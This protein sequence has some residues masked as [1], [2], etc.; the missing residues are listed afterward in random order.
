MCRFCVFLVSVVPG[1]GLFI[2]GKNYG[3]IEGA[4]HVSTLEVEGGHHAGGAGTATTV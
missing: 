1:R 4:F 2:K 3:D